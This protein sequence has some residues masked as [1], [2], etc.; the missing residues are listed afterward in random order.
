VRFFLGVT[1]NHWYKYLAHLAPDE[2]NFWRP[3][4]LGFQA[5]DIGAPFLFKLH[6]PLNFVAGGGFFVKARQ[7]PVSLAWD[8]FG[9][10]NGAPNCDA[11]LSLIRSYRGGQERDP[12][13][14][15]IMSE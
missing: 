12:N 5:I 4:G 8:A 13:I 11:R 1:N 3:S 7:L 15:C 9:P 10:K 14:G 2:V 6:S